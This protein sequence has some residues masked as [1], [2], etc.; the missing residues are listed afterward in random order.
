MN[1]LRLRSLQNYQHYTLSMGMVGLMT[2]SVS[3]TFPSFKF[4]LQAFVFGVTAPIPVVLSLWW[5]DS[6][7]SRVSVLYDAPD[8]LSG[9]IWSCSILSAKLN[10]GLSFNCG[11]QQALM[12]TRLQC[13]QDSVN[14]KVSRWLNSV[15]AHS[16]CSV[17]YMLVIDIEVCRSHTEASNSYL[18]RSF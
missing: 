8:I 11:L 13:W 2:F 15:V 10:I 14:T 16:C 6:R 3:L 4:L 5:A 12:N 9:F 1:F 7:L 17:H 18:L